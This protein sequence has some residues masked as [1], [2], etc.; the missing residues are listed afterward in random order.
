[1]NSGA[2]PLRNVIARHGL[3]ASKALGQNFILDRQL[4]AR[5]A[6]VPGELAGETVD[7]KAKDT[8]DVLA[9]IVAAFTAGLAS[10]AGQ[11]AVH[12][13]RIADLESRDAGTNNRD[14]AGGFRAHHQRQLALGE[15]HAAVAPDVD[16]IETDGAHANLDFVGRGGSGRV[17]LG[18]FQLAIAQ[19][20]QCTHG[21]SVRA[22]KRARVSCL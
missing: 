9:E 13:D 15:G 22:A 7:M 16:V 5:I 1:M 18:D 12:G 20:T 3:T 6:S 10:P 21:G 19:Q 17:D 14:L 4:L 2:E 8:R 11:R